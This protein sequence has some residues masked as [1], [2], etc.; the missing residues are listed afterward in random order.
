MMTTAPPVSLNHDQASRFQAYLQIY[1]RYIFAHLAP[2]VE[3]NT[4]LRILQA[5]QG[6]LIALMDQQ[7]PLLTLVLTT[8]E[9]TTLKT[10]IADLLL[11]YTR[12]QVSEDR[13]NIMADLARLKTFLTGLEPSR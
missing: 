8:E 9:L 4:I 13:N 11:L 7:I 2:S 12:E 1:R 5:V 6:K 3:R 10:I